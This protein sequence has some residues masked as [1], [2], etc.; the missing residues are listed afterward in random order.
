M[1]FEGELA[2]SFDLAEEGS[3]LV[4]LDGDRVA[5]LLTFRNGN[6][7]AILNRGPTRGDDLAQ[8]CVDASA[9]DVLPQLLDR[10]ESDG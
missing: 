6:P 10:L 9:G 4:D 2:P 3:F 7:V 5:D 1:S 8:L